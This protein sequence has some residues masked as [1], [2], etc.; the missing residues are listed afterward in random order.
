MRALLEESKVPV[1]F[2]ARLAAVKMDGKRIVSISMENGDQFVA[3][4]FIDCTYEGDLMAKAGVPYMVGR[5][6]NAR[7]GE[8]LNGVRGETPKHQ[9]LV[10]V[11]PYVKAGD[12]ASG[13]LPFCRPRRS[14]R[15]ARATRACRLTTSACA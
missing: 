11:D 9:F 8:T 13:L 5:E 15:R 1:F 2:E 4:M 10:P 7:F 3:S 12:P 14:G 6:A